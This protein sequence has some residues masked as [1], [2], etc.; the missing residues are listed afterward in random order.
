MITV[1]FIDVLLLFAAF[2]FAS[3]ALGWIVGY[4]S[5]KRKMSR[6]MRAW[7]HDLRKIAERS[8]TKIEE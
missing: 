3:F 7:L 8:K 6:F 2:L 1:N 4:E 5:G